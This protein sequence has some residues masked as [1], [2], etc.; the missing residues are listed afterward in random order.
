MNTRVKWTNETLEEVMDVIENARTSLKK[1][2][3]H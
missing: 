3:R 1:E 2:S